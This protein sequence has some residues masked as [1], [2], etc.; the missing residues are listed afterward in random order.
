[1]EKLAFPR[2]S[3]STILFLHLLLLF[4]VSR[5]ASADPNTALRDYVNLPDDNYDVIP[6]FS[7][8][9]PGF[10]L[11][12]LQMY[13]QQWRDES[14]TTH[15]VW[16]HL[17][18]IFEPDLLLSD[19][20]MLI[21]NGGSNPVT[22]AF[23]PELG[24]IVANIAMATASIIAM[25][26]Q[27]PNQPIQFFDLPDPVQ[28]DA[29]VA[30]TWDKAM[31]T[32]DD[33]WPVYLPMVKSVV[34]AM[35]TLQDFAN[36][37]MEHTINEFVLTG[38]SKRGAAV[39][40]T[41]A[42]DARVL[43]IAPGVIDF[44]NLAPHIE[45]HFRAY[46]FYS[47][48]LDDYVDFD[49]VRRVRTPEGQDLLRIVDPYE[50][51]NLLS[52]P[53]FLINSSGDEFFLPDSARFY[54]QDLL[55]EKLIRYVPNTGHDLSNSV[56]GIQNAI[57]SLISWYASVITNTP[58]PVMQWNHDS[59]N[60]A[61]AA[62]PQPRAARL[63]QAHNP[64]ARDF[65][66]N[67]IG[68]AWSSTELE[69]NPL[70]FYHA[71]VPAPA[72]GWRAYFIELEYP[73]LIGIPQTYSTQV[74]ITPDTLPFEV[75]DPLFDPRRMSFWKKEIKSVANDDDKGT[76]DSEMIL[77]FFPVPLFDTHIFSASQAYDIFFA[78]DEH[79]DALKHC[80]ATRFNVLNKELGWYTDLALKRY[81]TKKLWQHWQVAHNAYLS[82]QPETAK[83]IC[84]SINNLD[85]DS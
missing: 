26:S 49:I 23:D 67:E 56:S 14:E 10:K 35:D 6:L 20:A 25:V 60:L 44:L 37:E 11:H 18:T 61:V 64:N 24:P 72:Q 40:L 59:G 57:S 15:P 66:R 83:K 84:I 48:A 74:Y 31:R 82:N 73:S 46:G 65:R 68:E 63:W 22:P 70:G 16:S 4:T 36:S 3:C 77:S 78:E 19:K 58:R 21:V 41:A 80:L 30:Y 27:V 76:I 55:G 69:R 7:Q 28:E 38:F 9:Y 39:W 71:F 62:F 50:Y 53:K 34:K 13:S 43:A 8:D 79:N 1:M 45:H 33:F 12:F 47:S 29:L 2:K 32:G 54:F 75:V 5:L 52:L 81:G 85:P 42:V 17:I 51:R